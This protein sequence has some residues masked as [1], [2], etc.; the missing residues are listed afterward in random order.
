LGKE[1]IVV[2]LPHTWIWALC[3][4]AAGTAWS[5]PVKTLPRARC[6]FELPGPRWR[7]VDDGADGARGLVAVDEAG[8][9]LNLR[10][11]TVPEGLVLDE[12]F[13]A[14]IEASVFQDD[15]PRKLADRRFTY[16]GAPAYQVDVA[17]DDEDIFGTIRLLLANGRLYRLQLMTRLDPRRNRVAIDNILSGFSF[18]SPPRVPFQVPESAGARVFERSQWMIYVALAGLSAAILLL[19]W[20]G[21]SLHWRGDADEA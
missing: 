9:L 12:D 2:R 3:L 8:S 1:L 21:L 15:G 20:K 4:L 7:W 11:D 19:L 6:A 16:A 5:R 14:E 18:T 10:V 17:V 13:I